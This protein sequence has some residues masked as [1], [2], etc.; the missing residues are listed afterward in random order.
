MGL[1]FQLLVAHREPI[2]DQDDAG[3]D[4]HPL[5]LGAGMEELLNFGVRAEAHDALDPG[6]VVPTAVEEHH[7]PGGRQVR[8]VALEKPLRLLLLR[9]RRQGHDPA[10]A[11]VEVLSDALDDTAFAGG[12]SSLE[13]DHDFESLLAD[14]LV[15]FHQF[16]LQA[17]QFL[18]VELAFDLL[19][20]FLA[21]LLAGG[22]RPGVSALFVSGHDCLG[23]RLPC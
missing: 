11:R 16:H 18:P 8:H 5:E 1:S 12:I 3:T 7:F 4:E 13:Q 6:A 14:P 22:V 21:G 17:G 10:D 19:A 15:E 9:R 23:S 2:L 20:G